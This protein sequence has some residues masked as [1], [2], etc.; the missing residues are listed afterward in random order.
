MWVGGYYLLTTL[1]Q[2]LCLTRCLFRHD[3]KFFQYGGFLQVTSEIYN[4]HFFSW[5]NLKTCLIIS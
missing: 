3:G 2:E 1:K 4:G 5:F